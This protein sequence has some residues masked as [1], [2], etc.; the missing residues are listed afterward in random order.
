MSFLV[1]VDEWLQSASAENGDR[2]NNNAEEGESVYEDI[3]SVKLCKIIK[4]TLLYLII[5]IL[6]SMFRY[7]IA[8]SRSKIH[9]LN[10][11]SIYF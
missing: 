6:F 9:Y 4:G 11:M 1:N 5:P 10:S 8:I 7:S 2:E 3:T